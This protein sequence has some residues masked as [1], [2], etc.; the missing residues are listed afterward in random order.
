M[1][2]SIQ[3]VKFSYRLLKTKRFRRILFLVDR[4]ALGEQAE[5]EFQETRIEGL[6]TF[7]EIFDL[8]GLKDANPD[9]D[10]KAHIAT[11]QGLVKRILYPTDEVPSVDQYDCIVVDEC[12]RGYLPDS[13]I[14][15]RVVC[16]EL[17]RHIDPRTGS[18]RSAR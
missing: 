7:A 6:K 17:V 16:Q 15:D 10:T 5:G 3:S 1:I 12:H 9:P 2:D 14:S 4:T 8:K 13:Q 18:D 11:I